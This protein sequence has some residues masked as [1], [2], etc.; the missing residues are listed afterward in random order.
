M[1][2][3]FLTQVLPYPLVGGAKIRAY[4][5]L[6]HL[7][8][9]H[10]VTLVSFVREDDRME[11]VAHLAHCAA[12][13]TVPMVRSRIGMSWR[14]YRVLSPG[15]RSDARP[16]AGGAPLP[17]WRGDALRRRPRRPDGDGTVCPMPPSRVRCTATGERCWTSTMRCICSWSGRRPMNEVRPG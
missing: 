1:K 14:W 11:D 17:G 15:S 8:Q 13:H 12:V 16:G 7:A 4:Y 10:R 2:I 3:L 9:T 6:R 5:M